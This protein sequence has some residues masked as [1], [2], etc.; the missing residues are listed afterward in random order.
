L[1]FYFFFFLINMLFHATLAALAVSGTFAAP[2]AK[3]ASDDIVVELTG[4]GVPTWKAIGWSAFSA[5]E[6]TSPRNPGPFSQVKISFSDRI[7]EEVHDIE[8]TYRCALEDEDGNRIIVTRGT[9]VDFNFGNGGNDNAWDLKGG[10]F[11]NVKVKCDPEFRKIEPE[12]I[13]KVVVTLREVAGQPGPAIN[14]TPDH[15][16]SRIEVPISGHFRTVQV[17][18]GPGIENQKLRCQ[19]Q[20]AEGHVVLVDR[21]TNLNKE[22]FG[23]GGKG[24]WTLNVAGGGIAGVETVICDPA[25]V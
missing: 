12:A 5:A 4:H 10:P 24:E 25:F 20:N 17:S 22:T 23:D 3:R 8:N 9:S 1:I 15:I 13:N 6:V 18:I 19:L 7:K 11:A 2:S 21:G 16:T 14:L